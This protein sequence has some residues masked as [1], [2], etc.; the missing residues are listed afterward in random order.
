[1]D[2]IARTLPK[3]LTDPE[4]KLW[5]YLWAKQVEG[6]KLRSQ[7]PIGNY[8]VDFLCF[9]KRLVMEVDGGQ[10]AQE[11]YKDDIRDGWLREQGFQVLR[12]WDN[13]VMANI[14]GVLRP[15]PNPSRQSRGI[16]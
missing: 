15:S 9:E 4:R 16:L 1:M 2:S 5:R 8:M 3:D 12:S 11:R 7:G 14:Q 13:E 6:L 10:H